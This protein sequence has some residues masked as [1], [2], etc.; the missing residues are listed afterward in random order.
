MEHAEFAAVWK[1]IMLR[2]NTPGS[3]DIMDR[4]SCKPFFISV[5]SDLIWTLCIFKVSYFSIIKANFSEC[6][7]SCLHCGL[8]TGNLL[9]RS[10][11]S[12][13]S[14]FLKDTEF[15][16]MEGKCLWAERESME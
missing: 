16:R 11:D 15:T 5:Q 14:I 9:Q 13:Y 8:T 1:M 2:K 12:G 3:K 10:D 7:I 6:S 4:V